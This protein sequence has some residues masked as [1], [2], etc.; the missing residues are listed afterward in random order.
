[1]RLVKMDPNTGYVSSW[2]W[3]PKHYVNLA[4][5]KNALT[6]SF[7]DPYNPAATKTIC[8]WREAQ[9]HLLVPRA[10]WKAKGLPFRVVDLRPKSY[11]KTDVKSRIQLDHRLDPKQGKLVST[12]DDVQDKSINAMLASSGGG[13]Q[14]ACISGKANIGVNRG[15]KGFTTDLATACK[16]WIGTDRYAWDKTIPTYIRSHVGDRIGLQRVVAFVHRGVKPLHALRLEDGKVLELT[17]DHE[18]MTSSGFKAVK[19]LRSGDLVITDS[20]RTEPTGKKKVAYRRI[21]LFNHRPGAEAFGYGIPKA[22]A[23]K[24]INSTGRSEDVYDV[25]CADPHRNFVADGIVVHNCG[26]GKTIVAL[27]YFA[28]LQVPALIV[29]PDTQLLEQWRNAINEVLDVPGGVG[30]IQGDKFDWKRDIVLTTY[31]TIG[32]RADALPQE[33]LEWFGVVVWDE[34]HHIPAMTFAPSAH[35]FPGTRIY[36]TAT[37][38]RDDGMHI[39]VEYHIGEV[40]YKDLKQDLKPRMF[41]RW[42]GLQLDES[43]PSVSVRSSNGE[44]HLSMLSSHFGKWIDRMTMILEDAKLAVDGGRK[45]LVLSNSEAEIINMAMLWETLYGDYNGDLFSDIPEPTLQDINETLQPKEL[46]ATDVLEFERVVEALT[47][48]LVGY[49]AGSRDWLETKKTLDVY[50]LSLKRHEVF[51]ALRLEMDRRQKRFIKEVLPEMKTCGA[52]VHKVPPAMRT[53]FIRDRPVVFAIMKYGKEGLDSPDLDTVLVSTPFSSRN[54]L[55]QLMGRPTRSRE[56]KQTPTIVFYEDNVGPLIGMCS[57]LKKHLRDWAHEEG[58][59]FD[60]EQIGH[61]ISKKGTWEQNKA[62]IFGP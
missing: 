14:L 31:H 21:G 25:I 49:S 9:H 5:T 7:P 17:D 16:W 61:A 56:G 6:F 45:V 35:A 36:L 34:G 40:L 10:F 54:G 59:P 38:E 33:V 46:D 51:C 52:M 1:M 11:H 60:Y 22:V 48:R 4:G 44:L 53:K 27:E 2:L 30:L 23:I 3:I 15:G 39:V 32:A 28:R 19:D 41:F 18:V 42:T 24:S 37:P 47:Q 50:T 8:L 55:Q 29:V 62:R 26:K 43:D 20:D 12:G 58:G 13:L 57:K